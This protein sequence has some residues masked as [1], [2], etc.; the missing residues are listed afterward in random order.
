MSSQMILVTGATGK[1]GMPVVKQLLERGF[2]VRALAR[3]HDERS[4]RL[5]AL[6]A[7]VVLG[8]L[9]DLESM[10]TAMQNISRAYFCYP[11]QG[12]ILVEATSIFAVAAREAGVEAVVNMSQ[13]S[14]RDQAL[15][16]LSRQH[17]LSEHI[18][19]WADIGAIHI[20]PTFF[21][22]NLYLFGAQTIKA[23]GMLYLPYG[24]ERHAPVAAVD[25]ARVIVNILANPTLHIGE[26]YTVTGPHNL[27]IT[28]MAGVLTDVLG[29]SVEYVNLPIN[30]WGQILAGVPTMTESLITHLKAV[31]QDH[32]DGVFSSVT[33]VV[34]RIG[35]QTPQPL[36]DFISDNLAQFSVGKKPSCAC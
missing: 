18:L 33:D 30:D 7:Q 26:R 14:A 36:A 22:E 15:S 34:E 25:I 32:Q 21:A 17:W 35:G 3:R 8:D 16:P 9:L 5:S 27:T 13:I 2:S 19:D 4:E 23:D 12:E 29:R 28:E 6:G 24:S 1:T 31:A 20:R 10:R 11:P